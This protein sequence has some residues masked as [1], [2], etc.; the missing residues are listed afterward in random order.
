[1]RDAKLIF[2]Y[3]LRITHYVLPYTLIFFHESG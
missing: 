2:S 3:V 1:M